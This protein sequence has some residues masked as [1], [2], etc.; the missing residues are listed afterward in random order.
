MRSE[1]VWFVVA[2]TLGIFVS[3]ILSLL[4]K[5]PCVEEVREHGEW[6]CVRRL[7]ETC[8]HRIRDEHSDWRCVD[9]E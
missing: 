9:G 8:S 2:A 1:P 5:P 6:R 3:L 4:S 7:E